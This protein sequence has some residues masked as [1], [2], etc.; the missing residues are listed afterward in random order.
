MLITE[1]RRSI[2]KCHFHRA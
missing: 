1:L 2:R